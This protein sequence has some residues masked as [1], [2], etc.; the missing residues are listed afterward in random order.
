[1]CVYRLL[2]IAGLGALFF[3][4]RAIFFRID[5]TANIIQSRQNLTIGLRFVFIAGREAPWMAPH[6][7]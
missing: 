2:S 7:G 6:L 5:K 1:M 4:I 3:T